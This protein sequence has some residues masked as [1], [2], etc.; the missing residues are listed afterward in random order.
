MSAIAYIAPG[1]PGNT[2]L[3]GVG[4]P[5]YIQDE[6]SLARGRF[7]A[8]HI[9]A[10]NQRHTITSA[11]VWEGQLRVIVTYYDRWEQQNMT[12]DQV[13]AN[14]NADLQVIMSNLQ[15]NS[16]LVVGNAASSVSLTRVELSP[17]AG[18]LDDKKTVPGLTLVKRTLKLYINLLPYD[19]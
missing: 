18:E 12:I 13:R 6:Y 3:S 16:S 2:R 4:G 19:V 17:Y 5:V 15:D 9:Q 14:I 8:L 10:D 7:P 11:N 1:N